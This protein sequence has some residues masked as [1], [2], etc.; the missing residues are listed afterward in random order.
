M[1]FTRSGSIEN[2]P[3]FSEAHSENLSVGDKYLI[4]CHKVNDDFLDVYVVTDENGR[5]F[6]A[7]AFS[8]MPLEREG[9]YHARKRRM[10]RIC[11]SNNF[12]EEI[13]HDDGRRFLV[14][15]VQRNDKE[16]ADLKAQAGSRI[17][18]KNPSRLPE[19]HVENHHTEMEHFMPRLTSTSRQI[20]SS[21]YAEAAARSQNHDANVKPIVGGG[22]IRL[23]LGGSK[24][25]LEQ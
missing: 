25:S 9:L 13:R 18:V 15:N 21:S 6:E 2:P 4:Q 1:T 20:K 12:A 11:R 22:K 8:E 17:K 23:C 10:K 24:R 16:W 19:G 5:L 14:S 3:R 7:Q